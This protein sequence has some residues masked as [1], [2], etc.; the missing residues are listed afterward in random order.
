MVRYECMLREIRNWFILILFLERKNMVLN[1]EMS[2]FSI[3]MVECSELIFEELLIVNLSSIVIDQIEVRKLHD[4]S[5][6]LRDFSP[7]P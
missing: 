3:L 6:K 5:H 2:F 1:C 7:L 4:S